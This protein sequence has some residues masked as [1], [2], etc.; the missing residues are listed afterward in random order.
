MWDTGGRQGA[1]D[2]MLELFDGRKAAFEVTNL[3]TEDAL[4]TAS[5]L[6][7][8][9][10]RW[11]LPGQWVWDIQVGSA[12][13]LERLKAIYQ[14]IIGICEAKGVA[15]PSQLGWEPSADPDLRWLV[16]ESKS[17]MMGFPELPAKDSPKRDAMV[18]PSSRGGVIDDSLSGFA[19]A[20]NAEFRESPDIA[21][22][23]EK[24]AKA[25]ADERHLFIALH[26]SAL[27]FSI[28]S[29][30]M[31]GETLPSQPPPVPDGITHLWLAPAFSRR[32]LLWSRTKFWRN[33]FPYDRSR[34]GVNDGAHRATRSCVG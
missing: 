15:D 11:P 5:L 24:L 17:S 12:R 3:G 6:A 28:S 29:E 25:D 16:Q 10:H 2:A 23:F 20:L 8:D 27:P 22:H 33:V 21:S 26:D 32:V 7:R 9:N 18:V 19:A 4:H 34:A 1:V 14:K 13:D 30:L 31:F